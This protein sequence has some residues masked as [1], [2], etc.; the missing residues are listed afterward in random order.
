[1][2]QA[3]RLGAKAPKNSCLPID[4][5][6]EKRKT[7]REEARIQK[8]ISNLLWLHFTYNKLY[9]GDLK[10]ETFKLWN[11]HLIYELNLFTIQM[12]YYFDAC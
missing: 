3:I 1:M 4:E 10:K 11:K 12:V 5:L 9:S 8:V 7:E 2:A 6:K